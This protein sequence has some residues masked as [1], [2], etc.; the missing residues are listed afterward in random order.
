MRLAIFKA[1]GR[2]GNFAL[3]CNDIHLQFHLIHK[4]YNIAYLYVY[5]WE[6]IISTFKF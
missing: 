3:I 2:L 1:L 4:M 6:L 5:Y